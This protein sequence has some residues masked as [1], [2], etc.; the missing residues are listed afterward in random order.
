MAS[1]AEATAAAPGQPLAHQPQPQHQSDHGSARVAVDEVVAVEV[2]EETDYLYADGGNNS[3]SAAGGK[4]G[5]GGDGGGGGDDDGTVVVHKRT[6]RTGKGPPV[7]AA[8]AAV[9][10]KPAEVRKGTSKSQS[11]TLQK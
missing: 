10:A 5:G 8:A 11:A 7:A 2:V 3:G 6:K 9:A 4:A 1:E